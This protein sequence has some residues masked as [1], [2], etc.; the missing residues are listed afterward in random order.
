M[1]RTMEQMEQL[2]GH[3]L[4]RVDDV[5]KLYERQGA[6]MKSKVLEWKAEAKAATLVLQALQAQTAQLTSRVTGLE[7]E[8]RAERRRNEQLSQEQSDK[9]RA[10]VET[11]DNLLREQCRSLS[12]R[13]QA[14]VDAA[15][16]TLNKQREQ[17]EQSL[18]D[19][20]AQLRAQADASE[21][22]L[23]QEISRLRLEAA[24]S[25]SAATP[26]SSRPPTAAEL[27]PR[28]EALK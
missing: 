21:G 6:E 11:S 7:D 9:L 18:R 22:T 24:T 28:V 13:V 15:V 1:A 5:E 17:S 19:Y 8:L 23:R 10:Q 2:L 20:A 14:Q 26:N 25:L 16:L 3:A 12:E 4:S 27:G